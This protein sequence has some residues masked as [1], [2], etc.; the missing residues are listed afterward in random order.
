MQDG[1]LFVAPVCIEI[2]WCLANPFNLSLV[3]ARDNYE[4]IYG[5]EATSV[6]CTASKF[7]ARISDNEPALG[8]SVIRSSLLLDFENVYKE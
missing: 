6:Q 7:H 4:T 2:Q 5:S 1:N 8:C 3:R